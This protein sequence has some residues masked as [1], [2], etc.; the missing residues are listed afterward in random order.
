MLHR[1]ASGAALCACA[2]LITGGL[3]AACGASTLVECQLTAV[4]A[5]PLG[6]PDAITIGDARRL[7][8]RLQACAQREGDA[9]AE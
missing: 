6:D 1:I 7:A 2:F 9:G 8:E 3:V 5:L 4:H